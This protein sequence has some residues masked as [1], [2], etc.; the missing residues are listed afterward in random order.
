MIVPPVDEQFVSDALNTID[1]PPS[2]RDIAELW[3]D[4]NQ[5]RWM[6]GAEYGRAIE[7]VIPQVEY[8]MPQSGEAA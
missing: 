8:Y 5:E 1:P 4:H 7:K 2:A 6:T 3:V